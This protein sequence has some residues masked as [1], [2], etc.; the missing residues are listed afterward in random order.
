MSAWGH[1]PAELIEEGLHDVG[2]DGGQDQAEG[3]VAFRANGAEQVDGGVALVLDAGRTGAF[4]VPAPA[5]AAGLADSGLV[6]QPDLDALG[7]GMGGGCLSD[8]ITEFFLKSAWA[9]RSALGCTGRV[10]CQERSRLFSSLSMPFS[11]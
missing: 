3:G 5:V 11:L 7:L 10:F 6:L 1:L 9:L 4:L 8:Q 2:R